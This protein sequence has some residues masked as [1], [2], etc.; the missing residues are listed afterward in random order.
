MS[1]IMRIEE[2][3]ISIENY[4]RNKEKQIISIQKIKKNTVVQYYIVN[5]NLD[6]V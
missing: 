1:I 6:A 2:K 3:T 4:A 5:N